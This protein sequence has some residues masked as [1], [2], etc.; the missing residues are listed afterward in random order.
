MAS[1]SFFSAHGRKTIPEV[2]KIQH[3]RADQQFHIHGPK[4]IK[5]LLQEYRSGTDC[6]CGKCAYFSATKGSSPFIFAIVSS[7][8]FVLPPNSSTW[9]IG[10]R[11]CYI[12]PYRRTLHHTSISCPGFPHVDKALIQSQEP[13]STI[14]T[15]SKSK[16]ILR[17]TF[18]SRPLP[19]DLLLHRDRIG[20][21]YGFFFLPN[22]QKAFRAK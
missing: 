4:G 19:A 18:N 13:L 12:R 21:V 6:R 9:Q 20:P 10:T 1:A 16:S 5:F 8:S 3:R 7:A 15:E 14:S 11:R 22:N 17:T 2:I